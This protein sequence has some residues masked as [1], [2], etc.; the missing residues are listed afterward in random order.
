LSGGQR[1]RLRLARALYAAPDVLLAVEPTSAVDALT[2]AAVVDRLRVAR[3]GLTTV[4]TTTSPL[5]L[6]QADEVIFLA[7]GR[8]T[9]SGTHEEL[10]RDNA[11]YRDLVSRVQD[12]Q[13]GP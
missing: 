8:A 9:A 7:H 12:G 4:V 2:E 1:Q 3:R 5:V 11:A 13:V 10:L 6:D